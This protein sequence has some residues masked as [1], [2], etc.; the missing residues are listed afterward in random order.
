[1]RSAISVER[2]TLCEHESCPRRYS[3]DH[4][5][6]STFA[7]NYCIWFL[8]AK[9]P[10]QRFLFIVFLIQITKIN[11]LF[12]NPIQFV[13]VQSIQSTECWR[14]FRICAS[15]SSSLTFLAVSDDIVG[16]FS[17]LHWFRD[18]SRTLDCSILSFAANLLVNHTQHFWFAFF[19]VFLCVFVI[20]FGA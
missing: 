14:I 13:S 16:T 17:A 5:P 6:C 10:S 4:R 2:R 11:C 15:F 18:T 12:F 7:R 3:R 20:L 19:S 9:P 1:M 8:E